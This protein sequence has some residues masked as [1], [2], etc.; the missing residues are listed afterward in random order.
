[1]QWGW[2]WSTDTCGEGGAG[3][4]TC[5]EGGAN[6]LTFAMRV[7]LVYWHVVRVG[8]V[9]WHVVRVGLVYWHL[10]WGWSWSTD[11]WWGL[12]GLLTLAVR[13]GLVYW[14]VVRVGLVYWHVVRMGLVCWHL[15][16]GRLVLRWWEKAEKMYVIAQSV[17]TYLR[18]TVQSMM[19]SLA[20][21]CRVTDAA[22]AKLSCL[23]EI[24]GHYLCSW[25]A[26]LMRIQN[27]GNRRRRTVL[28]FLIWIEAQTC[29]KPVLHFGFRLEVKC[30]L[31]GSFSGPENHFVTWCKQ[32]YNDF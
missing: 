14:H 12:G 10:Q 13:V 17:S 15:W 18:L 25:T 6:L 21:K 32:F 5:G 3:L 9:Y 29:C 1:M 8:L 23:R 27:I 28:N 26:D 16:W 19:V 7:G 31:N 30:F 11:M 22:M 24:F 4:L 20:R 2:G